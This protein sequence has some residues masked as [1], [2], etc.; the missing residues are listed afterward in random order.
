MARLKRV[1]MVGLP[2]HIT[3][4]GNGRRDVFLTDGLKQTY[5]D[6][7][8]RE[9]GVHGMRILAYCLMTNHLHL[10]VIPQTECSLAGALRHAH[11]RFA[12]HWNTVQDSVG[13]MWQDRYYSCVVQPAGVW[14]VMRYVELNPLRAGMVEQAV[15]YPWSS[16]AAHVSG[17]D[18][19]GLLD[20]DWWRREWCGG[21]WGAALQ[22]GEEGGGDS[23]RR[24]TYTGRPL[25]DA[26]FVADLERRL[27][28][29]LAPQVGGRPRK[30]RE[31]GQM[32]M[33][34]GSG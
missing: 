27:G 8:R 4:R 20:M 11:G 12:Q 3:Q 1:V 16:A 31:D 15:D 14:A 2:H 22:L 10:V 6:L 33:E 19:S 7:L 5:L 29:R 32:L 18:A 28:R 25:G 23:I 26:Q 13:H 9:G 34:M 21:D 24:A 17:R 30:I